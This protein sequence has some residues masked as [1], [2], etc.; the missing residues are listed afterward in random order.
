MSFELALLE[1]YMPLK[2]GILQPKHAS[3]LYGHYI[4]IERVPIDRFYNQV[5]RVTKQLKHIKMNI[6][7][8]LAN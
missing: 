3:K 8:I 5:K 1:L 4:V 6:I 7:V 2:H